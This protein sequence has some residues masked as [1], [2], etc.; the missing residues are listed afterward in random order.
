MKLSSMIKSKWTRGGSIE[1]YLNQT[2]KTLNLD[3][4]NTHILPQI[5]EENYQDRLDGDKI[6]GISHIF[7]QKKVCLSTLDVESQESTDRLQL[8]ERLLKIEKEIAAK[9]SSVIGEHNKTAKK[10]DSALNS[11]RVT[12]E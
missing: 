12:L 11:S 8:K 10:A 2:V 3:L 5:C 9:K 7:I 6:D 4:R 1:E